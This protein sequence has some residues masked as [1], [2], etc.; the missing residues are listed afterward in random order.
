MGLGTTGKNVNEVRPGFISSGDCRVVGGRDSTS[1]TTGLSVSLVL[2]R[3]SARYRDPFASV[4]GRDPKT[5]FEMFLIIIII[6][7]HCVTPVE[8]MLRVKDIR[9]YTCICS[10]FRL[11]RS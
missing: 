1:H 5:L 10:V 2:N 11:L 9:D 6:V 4:C 8:R 7:C 3:F